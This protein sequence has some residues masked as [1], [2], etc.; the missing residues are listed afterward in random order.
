MK[1]EKFCKAVAF[2]CVVLLITLSS[3]CSTNN[4]EVVQSTI[5]ED[6]FTIMSE[7]SE[8]EID[9]IT[10]A[11]SDSTDVTVST[12]GN[13]TSKPTNK[14]SSTTT[15]SQNDLNGRIIKIGS[16]WGEQYDLDPGQSEYCDVYRE[17]IKELEKKYNCTITIE[18]IDPDNSVS[19]ITNSVMADTYT[20]DLV[21]VNLPSARNLA[22]AQTLL[23][24]AKLKDINLQDPRFKQTINE[25]VTFNGKVYGSG[26]VTNSLQGV[27]FNK[28]ILQE[29]NQ[30]NI[31]QLYENNEW[32]WDKFEEICKA[33]TK[34]SNIPA[35]C[36]YG[37]SN[38]TVM[39]GMALTANAGSTVSRDSSGKYIIG[40]ASEQ[41]IYAMNWIRKLM[42]E[43]GVYY[44]TST[45]YM[46]SLNYFAGGQA[47]FFPFY[48][49]YAQNLS[50]KMLDE[51]G[52]VAMP[53]GP[54]QS[55][56]I[57]GQYDSNVF[58]IPKNVENPN[59]IAMVYYDLASISSDLWEARQDQ[60][61]CW[62]FDDDAIKSLNDIVSNNMRPEYSGGPDYSAFSPQMNDS[63]Y[64]RSGNPAS[65]MASVK[66][67]FQ[68]TT[69]DYYNAFN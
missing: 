61:R 58:A 49:S 51:F 37:I 68:K 66:S 8:E 55:D 47:T 10:D 15:T 34:I 20:Y 69:D 17:K 48:A 25:C 18:K 54:A 3:G 36:V 6:S 35:N 32:T 31:Y 56:C 38:C 60:Y 27:F 45:D 52:F 9:I 64:K 33:T 19:L 43:D 40:M 46:A 53:R 41:G 13:T 65:V 12:G 5:S 2:A 22:R 24:Q 50:N 21:E 44:F 30:P 7:P 67:Q 4:T 57:C 1:K 14:S 39:L 11:T 26:Y 29:N 16:V 42:F 62:G 59:E 28:R 23:D 63:V